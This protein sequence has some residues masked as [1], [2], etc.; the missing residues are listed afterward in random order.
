MKNTRK[1]AKAAKPKT[2][3]QF[4]DEQLKIVYTELDA[5]QN[6]VTAFLKALYSS[7]EDLKIESKIEGSPLAYLNDSHHLQQLFHSVELAESAI[8]WV[9]SPFS[10]TFPD[11]PSVIRGYRPVVPE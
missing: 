9:G 2:A 10:I 8:Q 4:T 3:I 5:W 11:A 6:K 7:V 1:A